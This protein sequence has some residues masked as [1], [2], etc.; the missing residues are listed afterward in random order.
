MNYR[1]LTNNPMIYDE[2]AVNMEFIEGTPLNLFKTIREQ[3]LKG[4]K[5]ITHPLTSSLPPNVNPYKTVFLSLQAYK[6]IDVESFNIIEKSIEYTE[7]LMENR[8]IP[9]WDEKSLK[10]FQLVDKDLIKHLL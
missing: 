9:S 10:D 2:K 1:C 5:L 7:S 8:P 6:E 4:Y 3:I